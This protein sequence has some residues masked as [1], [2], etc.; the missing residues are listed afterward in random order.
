MFGNTLLKKFEE[1][2]EL[3][4]KKHQRDDDSDDDEAKEKEE[5]VEEYVDKTVTDYESIFIFCILWSIG[6]F[7]EGDDRRK[8]EI[9]MHKHTKLKMPRLPDGDSIFNYNVI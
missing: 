9:Y 8:L 6:A 5:K 3:N 2:Q 1:K 7:V 4:K